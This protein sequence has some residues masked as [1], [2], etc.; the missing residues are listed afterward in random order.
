MAGF[1]SPPGMSRDCGAVVY[2]GNGIFA[3]C[4]R[5][6]AGAQQ[7]ACARVLQDAGL[8]VHETPKRA[9]HF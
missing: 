2:V 9:S 8:P 6:V 7:Q 5:G 4:V 3:C 1:A